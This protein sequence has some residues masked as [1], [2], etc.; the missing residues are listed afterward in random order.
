MKKITFLVLS[1]LSVSFVMA[2]EKPKSDSTEEVKKET[3]NRPGPRIT[4]TEDKFEFGDIHQGDQVEHV[5]EFENTGTAPLILTDVRST[6]GCTIPKWPREPIPPGQ[7]SKIT[8]KFNSAGKS[9]NVN[10]VVKIVSNAVDPL[11]QV[12]ITTNILPKKEEVNK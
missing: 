9:G 7:K 4:F 5:F 8:V 3:D 11:N 12:T 10:K 6:C 2:Q 1:I